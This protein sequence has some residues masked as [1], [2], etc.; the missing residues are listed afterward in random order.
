MPERPKSL[1]WMPLYINETKALRA[2]L[3]PAAFGALMAMRV[4]SWQEAVPGTLPDDD[5]RLA[6]ISGL[7]ESW[8]AHAEVL[9]EFFVPTQPD[10][11]GRPRIADPEVQKLFGVQFQKYLAASLKGRKGGRPP[12]DKGTK[13][14]EKLGETSA[15]SGLR[16]ALSSE[17]PEPLTQNTDGMKA[18]EKPEESSGSSRP[19]AEAAMLEREQRWLESPEGAEWRRSNPHS[20]RLPLKVHLG[21]RPAR[22]PDRSAD[23]SGDSDAR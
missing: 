13:Q 21:D 5:A 1:A 6:S 17:L 16:N 22:R 14:P 18:G 12:T 23:G 2:G 8:A 4:H 10:E 19:R 11:K 9:R 7:G 20:T 15:F 3:T